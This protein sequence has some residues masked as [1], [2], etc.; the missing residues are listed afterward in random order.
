MRYTTLQ[1]TQIKIS[2]I[3]LG[4][5]TFGQQNTEADGH[6]QIDFALDQGINFIDVAEMYPVPA[7]EGTYGDTEKIIGTWLKK[8]GRREEI[9]LATKIAGPNR[10]MEY[11]RE[12]LTFSKKNILLSI[13]KSLQRLQ[14]DY[15]DLYQL[16]W[17]ERKSNMFGQR[18][19]KFQDDAWEDNFQEVL[20]TFQECIAQ[21]KIRAI[22][23]SNET[24]WGTMR[25]L[26]ESKMNNLPRIQTIQNPYSLLNRTFEV[27]LSEMCYHEKVGLLA[28]SPLGFG[29]LSGKFLEGQKHPDARIT[30]FPNFSRY[31][32]AQ[33]TQATKLYRDIAHSHG[34]TLTELA[35][36]FVHQQPFVSSTII[37]ATTFKQL[38][39]NIKTHTVVLS[40][41]ILHE[42]DRV[43]ELIPNPAP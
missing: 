8:N 27:G 13:E 41:E 38:E 9:V 17:P 18:G 37:G 31:N 12:D 3:G 28:Y 5:M 40:N 1:N 39:E 21:G 34:L 6:Q 10:G 11:V 24:P 14:T 15:I 29:V 25:F 43:Q 33:S 23:V 20:T 7:R 22:G 19:F 30:L 16:H 2:K 35:L 36:G 26:E 32:S 42:I 4:T